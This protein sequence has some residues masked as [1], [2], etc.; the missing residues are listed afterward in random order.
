MT[1]NEMIDV[2]DIQTDTWKHSLIPK[3]LIKMVL[4]H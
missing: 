1:K 4:S 3:L 2:D